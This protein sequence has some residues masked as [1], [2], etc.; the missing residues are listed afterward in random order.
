MRS[1]PTLA[2]CLLLA[3]AAQAQ[4]LNVITGVEVKDSGNS[5]VL[6]V[7]GSKPPNFT[8]FSMADPAR[9]VID[10][11]EARFQGVPEDMRVDDGVIRVVKNLAYGSGASAIARVMIAFSVDVEPPDVQTDGTSL[12]VKVAKPAGTAVAAAGG[13]PSGASVAGAG[14]SASGAGAAAAAA[15]AAAALAR[16]EADEAARQEALAREQREAEAR[17]QARLAAEATAK[18]REAQD[19]AEAEARAREAQQLAAQQAAADEAARVAADARRAEIKA[20]AAAETAMA[21]QLAA[22]TPAATSPGA[23][24][25]AS[26]AVAVD[27]AAQAEAERAASAQAKAD[28]RARRDIEQALAAKQAA[29]GETRVDSAP[30]AA[31]P[32]APPAAP[33]TTA[34]AAATATVKSALAAPAASGR[35]ARLQAVG[36]KQLP[37]V[38]RVFVKTSAPSRFTISDLGDDVVRLEVE[39]TRAARRND[40]RPLDTSFFP[41]AVA[42]ITPSRKGTSYVVDIKLRKRVPYQQKVEGDVVAIDFERPPGEGSPAGEATPAAAAAGPEAL[43]NA[44]GLTVTPED[45]AEG[46]EPDGDPEAAPKQ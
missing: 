27:P 29:E 31:T 23:A 15:A 12:T 21:Q 38:S 11:S 37:T 24:A 33:P 43:D 20:K 34:A 17:E 39:N 14:D 13:A 16:S 28:A 1:S 35:P 9:F 30:P 40:T 32:A 46:A 22:E 2:L 19:R 44:Q 26:V 25:P 3:G 42:M 7:K 5:V 18:E 36:F 8:T 45:K 4:E 10:L 41:S 6:T